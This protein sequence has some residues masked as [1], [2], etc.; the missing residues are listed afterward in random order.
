MTARTEGWPVGLYLAALI[1][2][3]RHGDVLTIAGD[4]RYVAD[5]L[6]QESLGQLPEGVQRFL[7]RTAVLDQLCAPLCDAILAESGAGAG[8]ETWRRRACSWSRWTAGEGGIAI[9]RCSASSYSVNS[10][11]VEPDA[12]ANLHLRAADWYESN[13][14]PAL[15]VEHLLNT[16]ERDRS[17]HLV[18]ELALPTYQ[19]GQLSTVQRWSRPSA[20]LR[21]SLSPTRGDGR[22]LAAL[23][24]QTGD[25]QRWAAS[26][27]PS[28]RPRARERHGIVR[29]VARPCSGH[30]VSRRSRTDGTDAVCRRRGAALEP[31]RASAV[32]CA[33]RLNCSSPTVIG[34]LPCSGTSAG[35]RCWATST[36]LSSA[37]PS[38]Q[39]SRWIAGDGLR[40]LS[41]SSRARRDR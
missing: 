19:A 30:H 15:A 23:T 27:T 13:G 1:A 40:P 18:T 28:L 22:R 2:N 8:F 10:S 39:C 9:M 34:R 26:S 6:Y 20:S 33:P 35:L 3:D 7:R 38:W 36:P 41:T 16:T 24:G 31:W 32:I 17:V 29:L 11:Q 5:Y 12:I 37:R 14:S 25:A 21:S 4:D